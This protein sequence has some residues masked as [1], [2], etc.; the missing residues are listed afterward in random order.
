MRWLRLRSS[1]WSASAKRT[2]VRFADSGTWR[3]TDGRWLARLRPAGMVSLG[4]TRLLY[5]TAGVVD[6][7][8]TGAGHDQ[9][10]GVKLSRYQNVP[11]APSIL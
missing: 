11:Y 4:A 8:Y 7:G 9:R 10:G 2:S 1:V 5:S 3:R 6:P